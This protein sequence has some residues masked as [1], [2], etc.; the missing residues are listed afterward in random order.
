MRDRAREGPK[1][2]LWSARPERRARREFTSGIVGGKRTR[3]TG[4]VRAGGGAGGAVHSDA[5]ASACTRLATGVAVAVAVV[6]A[7]APAADAQLFFASRPSPGLAVAPLF[8]E[9]IVEPGASDVTVDLLFG[10]I[11]PADRSALDFEQSLYLLWPGA[12]A[13]PDL[14]T[15][16]P[17]PA[18][19]KAVEA[20][21]V[22]VIAEGRLP[23]SARRGYESDTGAEGVPEGAPFVTV[24]RTGGPLGLSTPATYIRIPWTP[25]LVNRAWLMNLQF[26]ARGLV[27]PKVTTWLE[28]TMRGPRSSV[29]LGWSDVG[30]PAMFAVYFGQRDR[31]LP[32]AHPSQLTLSF[33]GS[34]T[35]GVDAITPRTSRREL[36][37]SRDSTT[38]V[39]LFL[40]RGEGLT[41]EVLTV[42][43]GYFSRWQTWAPV[44]IPVLFFVLGNVAGVLIRYFAQVL[45]TQVAARL[46]FGRA[47]ESGAPRERGVVLGRDRLARIVP[48]ET[49][50]AQ[51]LE[52]CG[53]DAEE[54]EGRAAPERKTLVYRGRREV[55]QRS[56]SL[57][58]LSRIAYWTIEHHEVTITFAHD[59]VSD[60]DTNV[61]RTRLSEAARV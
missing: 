49:T 17:E 3:E 36:S 24:V 35:L 6:S 31:V 28:R 38:V 26:V 42:D 34:E 23:L 40:E 50:Y 55:P 25:R 33:T 10:A 44:V 32:L 13:S 53:P 61:R 12:V 11:V 19:A 52:L 60:V 37:Q 29:S 54:S 15:G 16:P 41:P 56:W 14:S 1:R 58:W 48:G 21:G 47:E 30:S 39:S 4:G 46:R 45:G 8:I 59:V 27:K 51:V 5:M 7:A 20:Y 22:S 43:F 18:L 57:G 9:S 2:P